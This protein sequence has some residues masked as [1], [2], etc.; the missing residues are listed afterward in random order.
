MNFVLPKNDFKVSMNKSIAGSE[1][2][3]G[4]LHNILQCDRY[5]LS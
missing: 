2:C 3:G 1:W 5:L 4:G